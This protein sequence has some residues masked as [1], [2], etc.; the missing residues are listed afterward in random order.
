VFKTQ[1]CIYVVAQIRRQRKVPDHG[2]SISLR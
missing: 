2:S 1:S